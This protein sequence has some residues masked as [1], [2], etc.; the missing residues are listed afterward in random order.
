MTWAL[1]KSQP[2]ICSLRTC[3]LQPAST[4]PSIS[5]PTR[6]GTG[7]EAG[8]ADENGTEKARREEKQRERGWL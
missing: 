5:T 1:R 6:F 3:S 4:F 7:V 8:Y 2:R